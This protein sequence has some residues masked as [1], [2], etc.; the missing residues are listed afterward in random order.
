MRRSSRWR[1]GRR[2]DSRSTASAIERAPTSLIAVPDRDGQLS[3]GLLVE[4]SIVARLLRVRLL[5]IDA[6]LIV[7]PARV[8]GATRPSHTLSRRSIGAGL[9]AAERFLDEGAVSLAA[10]RGRD[11]TRRRRPQSGIS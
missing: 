9:T 11:R 3:E 2:D 1:R 7:S 8:K 5:A 10:S 6:R 4:A